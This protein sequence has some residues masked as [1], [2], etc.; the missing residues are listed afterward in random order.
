MELSINKYN[1]LDNKEGK[2]IAIAISII[3]KGDMPSI[4]IFEHDKD[5]R[6][7]KRINITG[8]GDNYNWG[9]ITQ[10]FTHKEEA[11]EWL[12]E[13]LKEIKEKIYRYRHLW[14]ENIYYAIEI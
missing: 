8:K 3:N 2:P 10:N 1:D 12:K 9:E 7:F 11:E 6:K 14:D 4:H 5:T 13:L